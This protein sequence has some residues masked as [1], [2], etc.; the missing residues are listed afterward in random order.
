MSAVVIPV[1]QRTPEWLEARTHGI[2]A[3]EA[4]AACNRSPWQSAVGLWAEKLGLVPPKGETLPMQ[5]GTALEPLIAALYEAETGT[6][7]RRVNQLRQHPTHAFMLASIDRRA[8]SR[9]VELKYSDRGMDYGEPGTDEVPEHV[10]LQVAHQMA[11]MDADEADVAAIIGG[12]PG[13]SIY[14]IKR[15]AGLEAG[16]IEREAEF[17]QHVISRTEPPL[18]TSEATARALRAMYPADDGTVLDA[19]PDLVALVDRLAAARAAKKVADEN[20]RAASTALL[21][22]IKNASGITGL[23][24][25]KKNKDSERVDWPSVAKDYRRLLEGK[26]PTEDL[27]FIRAAHTETALGARPLRLLSK[28][29]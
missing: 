20:E 22:V 10:L 13:V 21:D 29:D 23:L 14:H 9:L 6:K 3:S 16:V 24:A 19:T 25:A 27:E 12:R 7:L 5:I 11:V 18:D 17:W 2:G 28:G 1:R 26:V 4:A 8:G 15:H